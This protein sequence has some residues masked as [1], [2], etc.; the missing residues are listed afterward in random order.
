M[1]HPDDAEFLCAGALIRLQEKGWE[2]HIASMTPG[3]C[4]SMELPPEQIARVRIEEARSAASMI[5]AHYH[6]VDC[7]DLLILYDAP[8]L[9]RTVELV[10][11]VDPDLVITHSPHDY[12]VDHETTSQLARTA[13][14]GAPAPNFRTG[15]APCARAVRRIAHLYYASAIEGRDVFGDPAPFSL[16]IDISSVIGLKSDMLACHRSQREWLRAQHG[17]DEY[18]EAMRRWAAEVG[19]R[20]GVEY[21]EGFRQ[22]RGHAYPQ[23]DLLGETLGGLSP[24]GS[25]A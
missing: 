15:F 18:L 23:S 11:Q 21:A 13:C 7:R 20:V 2:V 12:L 10:R 9:R 5:R 3:D 19:R 14:F 17:M 24:K 16:A 25:A 6:C 1:A 4:G 22:H 8:T